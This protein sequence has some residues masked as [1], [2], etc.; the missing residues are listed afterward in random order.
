M[1]EMEVIRLQTG[2]KGGGVVV[3]RSAKGVP[4]ERCLACE[5]DAAGNR[6][7]VPKGRDEVCAEPIA[8]RGAALARRMKP[9]QLSP[10]R[11]CRQNT[12]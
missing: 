2:C 12:T 6:P 3:W 4:V 5:A 8:W 10:Q 9:L 11:G 1:S 7:F